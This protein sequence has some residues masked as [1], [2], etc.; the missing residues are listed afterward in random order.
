MRTQHNPK[1]NILVGR[2]S[3]TNTNPKQTTHLVQYAC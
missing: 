1:L 3:E 2:H